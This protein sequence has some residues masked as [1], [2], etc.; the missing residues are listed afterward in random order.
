MNSQQWAVYRLIKERSLMGLKTTQKQVCELV[1]GLVYDESFT[2]HD[3]CSA[4]WNI[5][6]DINESDEID[7]I[8]ITFSWETYNVGC[9]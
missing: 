1:E 6:K 2:S 4:L 5:I 8:I 9:S 3:H 7:K